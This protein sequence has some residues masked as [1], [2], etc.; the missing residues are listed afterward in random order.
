MKVWTEAEKRQ[1]LV[2][3]R[4]RQFAND[5]KASGMACTVPDEIVDWLKDE[6][7][8]EFFKHLEA[9]GLVR[10]AHQRHFWERGL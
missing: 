10:Q 6:E 7:I 2:R 4:A 3:A 1:M 8:P 5:V 9:F